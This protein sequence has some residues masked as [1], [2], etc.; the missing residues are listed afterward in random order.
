MMGHEGLA[1]PSSGGMM[2][3]F[4]PQSQR[5]GLVGWEHSLGH[6]HSLGF[7]LCFS[8]RGPWVSVPAVLTASCTD[9]GIEV[10]PS[11]PSILLDLERSGCVRG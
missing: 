9:L 4:F 11:A 1:C 6:V 10:S 8:S 5:V 3:P 7:N 2:S